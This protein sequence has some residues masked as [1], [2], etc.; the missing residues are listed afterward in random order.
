MS[1]SPIAAN[2]SANLF[3]WVDDGL[4]TRSLAYMNLN[5]YLQQASSQIAIEYWYTILRTRERLSTDSTRFDIRRALDME[6]I[7]LV[8]IWWKVNGPGTA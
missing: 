2:T 7:G 6:L 8:Q 3:K 4:N 1:H 5:S